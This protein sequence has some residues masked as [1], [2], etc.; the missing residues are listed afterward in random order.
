MNSNKATNVRCKFPIRTQI[1]QFQMQMK[2]KMILQYHKYV[3]IRNITKISMKTSIFTTTNHAVLA[4]KQSLSLQNWCE[5]KR[6][7]IQ[8][9]PLQ[10]PTKLDKTIAKK[11]TTYF[12]SGVEQVVRFLE[13]DDRCDDR[14]W[15]WWWFRACAHLLTKSNDNPNPGKTDLSVASLERLLKNQSSRIDAFGIA[16]PPS[17][18]EAT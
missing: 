16:W 10:N 6:G 9:W 4:F 7:E 18:Q 3:Q 13:D 15:K 17:A 1:I 12:H 14:W 8:A 2:M 11:Q 5:I